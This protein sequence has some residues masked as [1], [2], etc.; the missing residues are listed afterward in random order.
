MDQQEI[1]RRLD[2]FVQNSKAAMERVPEKRD[3]KGNIIVDPPT[4]FSP[5]DI[6]SGRFIVQRD[7][8]RQKFRTIVNGV[9]VSLEDVL[10]GRAP[11]ENNDRPENLVD[12]FQ[13][14]RLSEMDSAGLRKAAIAEM[15]WS[16]DY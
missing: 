7:S 11:I 1:Q 10:P 16:D 14:A 2:E 8:V 13:Y 6:Q 9:I 12:R 15:P 5:E 3:E 4:A